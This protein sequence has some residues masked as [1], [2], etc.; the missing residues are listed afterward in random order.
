MLH[1]I[2]GSSCAIVGS[3]IK[4]GVCLTDVSQENINIE[5]IFRLRYPL[6]PENSLKHILLTCPDRYR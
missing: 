2:L 3:S 5:I 6:I 4:H 1:G